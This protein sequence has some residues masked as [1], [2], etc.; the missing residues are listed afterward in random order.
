MLT[1]E[2]AKLEALQKGYDAALEDL[3]SA[4][5]LAGQSV[6]DAGEGSPDPAATQSKADARYIPIGQRLEKA[7]DEWHRLWGG[8]QP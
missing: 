8:G 2:T 5:M 4:R 3:H 1:E 7:A 6:D